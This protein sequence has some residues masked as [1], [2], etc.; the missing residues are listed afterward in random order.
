M[1]DNI[2]NLF[3]F[4]NLLQPTRKSTPSYLFLNFLIRQTVQELPLTSTFLRQYDKR[5]AN[6]IFHKIMV[7]N[8]KTTNL[9]L[10]R[11]NN[12]FGRL[13]TIQSTWETVSR[14]INPRNYKKVL[15]KQPYILLTL[16][17]KI[18]DLSGMKLKAIVY[19]FESNLE[20]YI[21][22]RADP[23]LC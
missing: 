13:L 11:R 22:V 10:S 4:T 23:F 19:S 9:E 3:I 2:N 21:C 12:V 18:F 20:R 15:S 1:V 7:R 5:S 17:L 14:P 16:L 6:L 8:E